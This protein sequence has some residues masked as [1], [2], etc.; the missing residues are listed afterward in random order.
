MSGGGLRQINKEAGLAAARDPCRRVGM[1][2]GG[3]GF[4]LKR[5]WELGGRNGERML[6]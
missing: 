6:V 2:C 4:G 1:G 5:E 3:A